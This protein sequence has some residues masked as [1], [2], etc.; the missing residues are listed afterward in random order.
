MKHFSISH[1]GREFGLSRSTL[2]YYDRIGLLRPSGRSHAGYRLYG[3]AEYRK[4]ERICLYRQAGIPLNAIQTLLAVRGKPQAKLLEHR[5]QE[6]AQHMASLRRQQRLLSGMLQHVSA[7]GRPPMVDK[8]MW[9]QMLQAAGMDDA[10][11]E[12]WH[13]EFEHRAPGQHHDFLLSLGIE[14]SE[15]ARIRQWSAQHYTGAIGA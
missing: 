14:E 10:A 9:I 11:M 7:G 13:A 15:I 5:L 1:L 12:R 2:L 3:S 6:I 8:A 4:L